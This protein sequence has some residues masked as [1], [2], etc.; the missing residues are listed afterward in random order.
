[1]MVNHSQSVCVREWAAPDLGHDL[2]CCDFQV[3]TSRSYEFVGEG[4]VAW[5]AATNVCLA[6][7]FSVKLTKLLT[8]QGDSNEHLKLEFKALIIRNHI[9]TVSGLVSTLSCYATWYFVG[10]KTLVH[11]DLFVNSLVV[12]LMYRYNKKYYKYLC[13]PCI[14]LCLRKCDRTPSKL[15]KQKSLE[16]VKGNLEQTIEAI[17]MQP[18]SG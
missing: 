1:M 5:V 2:Q 8:L 4:T 14:L 17:E 15:T 3:T 6:M 16:F 9:L 10:E 18:L 12:G 7:L 11:L 13:R